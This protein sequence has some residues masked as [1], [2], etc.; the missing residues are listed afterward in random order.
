MYLNKGYKKKCKKGIDAL[1]TNRLTIES[2]TS[3]KIGYLS[4]FLDFFSSQWICNIPHHCNQVVWRGW[5]GQGDKIVAGSRLRASRV[6]V[7]IDWM[8]VW[9]WKCRFIVRTFSSLPSGGLGLTRWARL[10]SFPACPSKR[11]SSIEFQFLVSHAH[12]IYRHFIKIVAWNY[13]SACK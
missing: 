2:G 10:S 13:N 6:L 1:W 5:S 7:C 12:I 3:I 9:D 8:F 11:F 4:F